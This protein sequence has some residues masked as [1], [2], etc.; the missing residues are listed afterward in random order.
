MA[1]HWR[2]ALPELSPEHR[3]LAEPVASWLEQF[4]AWAQQ[5]AAAG[6]AAPDLVAAYRA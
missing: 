4:P 3:A 1:S 5:A 6:R 2:A